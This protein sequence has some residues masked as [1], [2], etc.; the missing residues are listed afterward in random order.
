MSKD[1]SNV[2]N[3][4]ELLVVKYGISEKQERNEFKKNAQLFILAEML[5]EERRKAKLTQKELANKIGTK[6]RYISRLE[7][8][9]ADIQ[10]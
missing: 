7:K 10:I 2:Q 5:K 8:A 1:Y 6:K 4:H 9:K 3:F